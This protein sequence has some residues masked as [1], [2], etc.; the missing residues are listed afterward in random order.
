[1][2]IFGSP[3]S[4]TE[5]YG[6]LQKQTRHDTLSS[7]IFWGEAVRRLR[8]EKPFSSQAFSARHLLRYYRREG[9]HAGLPMLSLEYHTL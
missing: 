2:V 6:N 3:P 5:R 7:Y 8:R 4:T 9:W 1:M